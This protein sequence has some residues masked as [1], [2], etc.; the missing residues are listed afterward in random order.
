VLRGINGT[1]WNISFSPI[2]EKLS[3]ANL[4]YF[5]SVGNHDVTGMPVGDR[6]RAQGLHNALAAM[7][8]LMPSEG[9]RGV[10]P[11]IRRFRLATGTRF[12]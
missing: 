2:I 11:D 3:A 6:T 9:R 7:S 1:M 8:K 10:S 5:F 4:P 12:S